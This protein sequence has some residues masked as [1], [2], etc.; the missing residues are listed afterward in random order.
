MTR[1][2]QFFLAL[3][4]LSSC[5]KEE[6]RAE[7]PPPEV[8]VVDVEPHDVPVW[9]DFV[10]QTQSSQ[11]VQIY[12]RVTGFLDKRV[13]TEGAIVH[14]GDVLFQMD[15]K[16]YQVQLD[17]AKAALA[18]QEA[19]LT[20]A[21]AKLARVRPLARLNAL[22]QKDLDNATGEVNAAQA[23]VD[24]AKANVAAA[25]LNLSYCT[26]ASPVTG[27]TAA[28]LQ[29][30][31]TYI[32][33]LNTKL[34]SVAVVSPMWVNYSVSE[35]QLLSIRTQLEKGLLRAPANDEHEVEIILSDGTVY[36]HKGRISFRAPS[37]NP[38][39]G[40][41]LVRATVENPDGLLLPNQFVQSRV[42]GFVRPGAMEVPQRA[43][44]QSAKG[45]FVWVVNDD[46]KAELRPVEVGDWH[47]DDWFISQ[48]LRAG[49]RV[50]VDGALTLQSG[51]MVK[52]E[53]LEGGEE[54]RTGS[55]TSPAQP[56]TR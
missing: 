52:A 25:E 43:V 2:P 11:D 4:L 23:A 47:E 37:Y 10:A 42:L 34:T 22:S 31:G 45:H 9:L 27:I 44:R 18:Q 24:Q 26:I 29:Q 13:Y 36:S 7:R 6:T 48:G 33:D 35:N 5:G 30:D 49:D 12:A 40:T 8:S 50:V 54:S 46:G 56:Q 1:I 55:T 21:A 15:Q 32:G 41:F 53:P 20:T 38:K 39:T 14:A 17:A 3:L 16:P 51:M 19:R 28:A